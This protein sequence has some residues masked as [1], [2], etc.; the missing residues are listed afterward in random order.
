M[1]V[2]NLAQFAKSLREEVEQVATLQVG[3]V[4]K[5]AARD[6]LYTAMRLTPVNTGSVV[7]NYRFYA[8]NVEAE[9]KVPPIDNGPPGPT[10]QMPLGS[11]PRRRPNEELSIEAFEKMSFSLPIVYT[12]VNNDP[13]AAGVE[14]GI[15]PPPPYRV[16]SSAM[17]ARAAALVRAKMEA[18]AYN[19]AS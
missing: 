13:D 10:N 2:S 15:F 17:V 3:Q 8:G 11:E 14:S 6:L 5:M 7:A 1:A 19:V 18:G 9:G 16:R 12:F 4:L